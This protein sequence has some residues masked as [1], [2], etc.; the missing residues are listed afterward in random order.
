MT[1]LPTQ[2]ATD[3][4]VTSSPT[5]KNKTWLGIVRAVRLAQV[6]GY[7]ARA[8][9]RGD[10]FGDR[11]ADVDALLVSHPTTGNLLSIPYVE[12]LPMEEAT[13]LE[14]LQAL[15]TPTQKG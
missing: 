11:E 12:L 5:R 10:R 7:D 3:T 1:T 8:F 9:L 2:Q 15:C 14:R 13:F 6:H 4:R